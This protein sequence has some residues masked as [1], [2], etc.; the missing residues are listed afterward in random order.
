[1]DISVCIVNWNTKIQIQE[2]LESI[3]TITKDV[4]YEIIVVDNNSTDG[5]RI[6]I[7]QFFPNCKLLSLDSN[8]GF[9]KANNVALEY[10]SGRYILFLNPDTVLITNALNG[11]F[12]F[13]EAHREYGAVG[14]KLLNADGTIQFTCACTYP[15]PF[16][17]FCR[18]LSL[19]HLF[20]KS[21]FFSSRLLDYWDHLDSRSVDCI[22]GACMM[23]RRELVYNLKGFDDNIYMYAEDLDL[24]YRIVKYP[25]Q[26]Y[27]LASEIIIHKEGS[28]TAQKKNILFS[29][30]LQCHY[31]YYFV[32]KH[33]GSFKSAQFRLSVLVGSVCRTVILLILAI[34]PKN[35]NILRSV[36][37]A[38]ALFK[39]WHVVLWSVGYLKHTKFQS[40]DK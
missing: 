11:M 8:I 16:N 12:S 37:V 7:E 17:E 14:C 34:L 39:Y 5:S 26:I 10:A 35:H 24:C 9:V 25:S 13:L 38:D 31:G 23:I 3:Y 22:S 30:I 32:A 15:T 28:S 36:T 21:K 6:A 20:S 2:C 27:Y 1:M 18:Y 29:P 4:T 33:F 40:L 19:N